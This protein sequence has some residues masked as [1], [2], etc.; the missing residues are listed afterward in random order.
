ME[1]CANPIVIE[2]FVTLSQRNQKFQILIG[3]K[4]NNKISLDIK[5]IAKLIFR[6]PNTIKIY[7]VCEK[8]LLKLGF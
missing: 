7:E 6:T 5:I 1:D 8:V 3:E 4:S 2:K